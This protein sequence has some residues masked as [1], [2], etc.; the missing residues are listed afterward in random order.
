MCLSA[1]RVC[2]C[3]F[4]CRFK[5]QLG[6][7]FASRIGGFSGFVQHKMN[8]IERAQRKM[9]GRCPSY[10]LLAKAEEENFNK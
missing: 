9:I 8:E 2:F 5:K 6:S 3:I 10:S 4:D 7:R 1:V